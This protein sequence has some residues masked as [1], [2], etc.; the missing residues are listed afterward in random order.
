MACLPN[1]IRT[2]E[3]WKEFG[4]EFWD[5]NSQRSISVC[6][7][8]TTSESAEAH[9]RLFEE[10]DFIVK[11]DTETPLQFYYL[12]HE[13]W[14]VITMDEHKGQVLGKQLSISA[15]IW[16]GLYL[17]GVARDITRCPVPANS[18]LPSFYHLSAYEHLSY[19]LRFYVTHHRR[20]ILA[21]V[22][23]LPQGVVHAMH[24]L[25]TVYPLKNL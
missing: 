21:L 20:Q 23:S 16:F 19:I 14:Q 11:L 22:S 18:T 24:S 12:H 8:F 25:A 6:R 5:T 13:D 15:Q 10:G 9:Q 1:L 2:S 4:I 7:A 17:S 3:G